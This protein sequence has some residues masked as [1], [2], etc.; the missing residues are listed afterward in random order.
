MYNP[1]G[2][3][4]AACSHMQQEA[5]VGCHR[6]GTGMYRY[7]YRECR[8]ELPFDTWLLLMEHGAPQGT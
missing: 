2:D 6:Q 1:W 5:C 3:V 8:I 4:N 7:V